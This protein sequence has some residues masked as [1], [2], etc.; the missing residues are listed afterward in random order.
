MANSIQTPASKSASA[1]T[2]DDENVVVLPEA[3]VLPKGATRDEVD[4]HWLFNFAEADI[5]PPPAYTPYDQALLGR[6]VQTSSYNI[7]PPEPNDAQLRAASRSSRVLRTLARLSPRQIS[8]LA[9]WAAPPVRAPESV[10]ALFGRLAFVTALTE[11]FEEIGS[12]ENFVRACTRAN[13]KRVKDDGTANFLRHAARVKLAIVREQ[14]EEILRDA[15]VAY[16]NAR[17]DVAADEQRADARAARERA[18]ALADILAL[19]ASDDGGR[20]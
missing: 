17:S 2:A 9:R 11:A 18:P 7:A 1:T 16:G 14:A 12:S 6:R 4:I 3:N 20:R 19:A 8:A 15:F 5:A 10:R 13:G